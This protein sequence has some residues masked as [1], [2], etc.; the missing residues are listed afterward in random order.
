[1]AT[2]M[3][4][5]SSTDIALQYIV[6]W[7]TKALS[8]QGTTS[9]QTS[10]KWRC[11]Y[12]SEEGDSGFSWS[13]WHRV[14]GHLSS[15]VSMATAVGTTACAHIDAAAADK[16][17]AVIR[18]AAAKAA[19][20]AS[21]KRARAN[22]DNTAPPPAPPAPLARRQVG[23][24]A[25]FS[26]VVAACVGIIPNSRVVCVG[27]SRLFSRESRLSF[28]CRRRR[29][30]RRRRRHK[31]TSSQGRR[32]SVTRLPRQLVA[33]GPRQSRQQPDPPHGIRLVSVLSNRRTI[34]KK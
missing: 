3:S 8:T 2:L 28:C 10:I 26:R 12:C 24:A 29:R 19:Q 13:S 15:D 5:K 31:A 17:K 34:N 33:S 4:L 27:I 30:R 32:E 20:K 23:I 7:E 6:L 25:A 18:E 1:M 11:L 16:F 9:S 21:L 22:V 14:R